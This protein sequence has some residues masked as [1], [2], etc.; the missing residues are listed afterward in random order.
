MNMISNN[1]QAMNNQF[2]FPFVEELFPVNNNVEAEYVEPSL[3]G[4]C[5]DCDYLR[6][7][8]YYENLCG[9]NPL[10]KGIYPNET[11]DEYGYCNY[12][13]DKS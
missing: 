13:S 11:V 12:F 7:G 3:Y 2:E 8:H 4:F 5:K 1:L 10:P 6:H 9:H